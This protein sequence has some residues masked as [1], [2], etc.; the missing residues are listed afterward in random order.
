[1]TSSDQSGDTP[2]LPKRSM[3]RRFAWLAFAIVAAI[4]LYTAG[5]YYLAGRLETTVAE[6]IGDARARGAE[7][8]CTRAQARGYPFRIGL[9]C[10]GVAYSD[11]RMGVSIS[12]TGLRSAAQIY[13]PTRI[14]GEL[15]RLSVD[16]AQA[17]IAIDMSDLR[18]STRL[19]SPLP[20]LVSVAGSGLLAADLSGAKLAAASAGQAHLRPR[21]QD[22]DLAG[23]ITALRLEPA[24]GAPAD[25]PAIDGDWDLTL[26]NG[27]ALL[28][29]GA[30]NLRGI[31]GEIRVL[32][33]T[34]G[35]ARVGISGPFAIG[36]DGLVDATLTVAI[37]GPTELI[38][39][40]NR[41]F[42]DMR[43]QLGQAAALLT[44]MGDSP[45]LPLAISKG[46]V[47]MGFFT[48]GL[49]P[50]LD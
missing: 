4:G 7:A 37:D 41:A 35:S 25:L 6:A 27:A 12:G 18:Y 50:P 44:A 23:S 15:D 14:V 28:R 39:I 5:W 34:S 21:G 48:L 49:I 22:L 3:S 19:S 26:T 24:T 32:T 46:E 17:G 10:D 16:V 20:D 11:R 30:G 31:A 33:A 42:P 45:R 9:F 1:M 43:P 13:Q 38:A 36:P 29:N 47:R 2:A 40:L 8:D